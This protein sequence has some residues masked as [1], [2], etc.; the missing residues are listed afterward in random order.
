MAVMVGNSAQFLREQ[1]SNALNE[2]AARLFFDR[3]AVENLYAAIRHAWQLIAVVEPVS[4]SRRNAVIDTLAVGVLRAVSEGERDV[5][6][7]ARAAYWYLISRGRPPA[8]L[9]VTPQ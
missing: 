7:L 4:A 1:S 9:S 6:R 3:A 2:A 5:G 8:L